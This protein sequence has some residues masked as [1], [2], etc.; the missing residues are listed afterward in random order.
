MD[1]VVGTIYGNVYTDT[2]LTV[3]TNDGAGNFAPG[4]KLYAAAPDP[5]AI[6]DINGDGKPDLV[7]AESPLS[8]LA[9]FFQ[10]PELSIARTTNTVV[11]SW[12]ASWTNWVFQ[13]NSDI[14]TTNWQDRSNVTN[15]GT[16]KSLTFPVSATNLFFRLLPPG[17]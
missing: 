15:D 8:R 2:G 1:L 11:I 14:S 5:L 13:E 3:L 9:V 16:N 7:A 10:V 17:N 12:P 6:A 4:T